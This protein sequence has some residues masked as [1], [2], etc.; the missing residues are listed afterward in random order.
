LLTGALALL[1]AADLP[2][3]DEARDAARRELSRP[4]YREA[5]PPWYLRLLLWLKDKL[6]EL[7]AR[8]SE[9]VP[10][11]GWGLLVLSLLV[12]LLVAV[13]VVRLRPT[14][15][16]AGGMALFEGTTGLTAAEHRA[17]AERAA[18]AGDYA[19][20]VQERFRAVV[21]ELESRG[22]LDVRPGRTADE[23]AREA[24]TALP[25]L[26]DGLMRGARL[27]DDVRYGGRAGDEPAYRVVVELD[28]QVL[29]T[30]LVMA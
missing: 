23:V 19:E 7:L 9:Q 27:F 8:A 1:R 18:S 29:R 22:V 20:A 15:R 28:E 5:Q 30:R 12:A 2:G 10:G 24:G 6:N 4:A 13:V 11:G 14:T 3:R 17:R 25:V 21:R 16:S 26:A